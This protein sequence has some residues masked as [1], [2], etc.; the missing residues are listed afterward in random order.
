MPRFLALLALTLAPLLAAAEEVISVYNWNDYIAP[1]VLLDFEKE[2]GIRVDY[3]TYSTAEELATAMASG[4]A[5]DVAVPSHDALPGL[6]KAAS[7]QPLDFK[8]LPNRSHLD[9]QLLSKLAAF[10]TNN[11]YAIPYLWG[12]V[13][14][15]INIPAAEQAFGGPLPDSWSVLFNPEQSKRLASCGMSVLDARDEVLSALMSYQGRSLAQ[16]PPSQMKRSGELLNQL[17]PNLQYVDSTRYIDDLAN[18][19]LCVAFAWVGD[20]L[21]AAKAGQPV[22]FVVP[23]EGSILFIDSLVIPRSARRAD[24]AHKFIDYLMQ[25]KVAALITTETLF[26]SANADA[27][28]FLDPS[29]RDQPGLY[30]DRDTKRRLAALEVLPEKLAPIRDQI[31]QSFIAAP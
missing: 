25:P 1:Q 13:G 16:T 8:L 10:D 4:T 11:K 12:S 17:R 9:K 28:E 26:P 5:I 3:H 19:K 18:G 20:A 24:L 23:Q 31:W 14:L 30:P 2:T 27:K 6:I 22:K 21:A 15:A 7:I 29:I